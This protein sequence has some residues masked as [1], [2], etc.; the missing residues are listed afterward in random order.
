MSTWLC[1]SDSEKDSW[2]RRVLK[3]ERVEWLSDIPASKDLESR[4]LLIE[5][6]SDIEKKEEALKAIADCK[7]WT[8]PVASLMVERSATFWSVKSGLGGRLVCFQP[9]PNAET[10]PAVELFE[11]EITLNENLQSVESFFKEVD[12]N[13]FICRDQMGGILPRVLAGMINEAAYMAYSGI[14]PVEK[15]DRMMRL[16]ANFP[17]GPFE[18]ADK[19]GLDRLMTLL[20]ALQKEFGPQYQPCPLIRRKVEGGN[21]GVKTG[22]GFY[23]Y[24]R[25]GLS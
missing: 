2:I 9:S 6:F 5:A 16:A 14:A 10:P 1:L 11:A 15:I 18:W 13:V 3:D 24:P 20:E 22:E 12:F 19:I 21:L 7:T 8:G 23:H 4:A 25:E 17:M